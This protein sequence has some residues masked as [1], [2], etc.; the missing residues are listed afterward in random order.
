LPILIRRLLERTS[1]V[2]IRVSSIEAHEIT[3]DLLELI[4]SSRRVCPHFHVPLQSG[5]DRTLSRMRRPYTAREYLN[6]IARIS[7]RVPGV[8]I[9][10]DVM[11]G[12]PGETQEEFRGTVAFL[13][14]APVHYLH[15]FP[16]SPRPGTESAGWA[17]DVSPPEK[18]RRV[19]ELLALD[20]AKR[21]SH[22]RSQSGKVLEVLAE[23]GR[24]GGRELC[25]RAENYSEV[26]FPA[27]RSTTGEV[28]PVR[29]V[30]T[31]NG[32]LTGV[33]DG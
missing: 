13:R 28:Y 6:T 2:R 7:V 23:R 14:E 19:A 31:R 18:K 15:A 5:C 32:V 4:A 24:S 3:E 22:A 11:A 29:I 17:D 1:R 33:I 25:G 20:R 10:A 9:G 26:L 21:K 12:F 8:A 27:G 16:Y 30:G